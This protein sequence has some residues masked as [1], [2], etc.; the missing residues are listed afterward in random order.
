[1]APVLFL[2]SE[3]TDPYR[4]Y[5]TMLAENRVYWDETNKLWAVYSYKA[6]KAVLENSAAQIPV[7]TAGNKDGL[8]EYALM[9]SSQLA[10]LS[11]GSAH[12]ATR[13]ITMH[14]FRHMKTI[15][16]AGLVN[17]L[18]A[19]VTGNETDWVNTICKRLPVLT[20]LKSLAFTDEDS[21]AIITNIDVL[22]KIMLPNKTPGQITNINAISKEVYQLVESHLLKSGL[23]QAVAQQAGDLFKTTAVELLMA[24]VSNCIGLFIQSYDAGRGLLSNCLLQLLKKDNMYTGNKEHL[25]NLVTETLRY[26][27][28]VHNTRRVAGMDL[29]LNDIT[30]RKG[31]HLL[32]VLAAAN[33]DPRHFDEPNRFDA[34]RINNHEHLTFGAGGHHCIAKHFA[35]ALAIECFAFVF[36]RYSNIQLTDHCIQYEPLVNVRL[37]KSILISLT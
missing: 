27:P 24:L 33:R 28:P 20:I 12:A 29:Q 15:G 35:V 22:V 34:H 30:I 2:Q 26:D 8:N 7:I 1:M 16:M 32:I 10:R 9:I 6:C 3:I 19:T 31:N 23:Y 36:E 13:S 14:L 37:P 4:L 11:N 25:T 21:H 18:L 5:Q 17:E